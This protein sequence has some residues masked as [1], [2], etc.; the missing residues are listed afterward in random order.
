LTLHC[1]DSDPSIPRFKTGIWDSPGS[2]QFRV[3]RKIKTIGSALPDKGL[4]GMKRLGTVHVL[5]SEMSK[6][7]EEEEKIVEKNPEA[8]DEGEETPQ[9]MKPKITKQRVTFSSHEITMQSQK[10]LLH[11]ESHGHIN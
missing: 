1:R 2:S 11:S 10:E 7:K 4:V 8:E 6:L 5:P 3:D 9:K